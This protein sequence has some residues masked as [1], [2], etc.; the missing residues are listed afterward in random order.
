MDGSNGMQAK[1]G[2]RTWEKEGR[3]E[4]RREEENQRRIGNGGIEKKEV[5]DWVRSW[6]GECNN[7]TDQ[8]GNT[9][10]M[11]LCHGEV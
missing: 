1:E 8:R 7:Q 4:G 3:E 10:M 2:R 11:S 6:F 5:I 9:Y